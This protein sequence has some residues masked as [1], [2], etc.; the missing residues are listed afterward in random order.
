MCVILN[1]FW[2]PQ[3]SWR[4]LRLGAHPVRA[5]SSG[6]MLEAPKTAPKT[7]A[8]GNHGAEVGEGESTRGT[9]EDQARLLP[10]PLVTVRPQAPLGSRVRKQTCGVAP[11]RLCCLPTPFLPEAALFS[12]VEGMWALSKGLPA[13]P[14]EQWLLSWSFVRFLSS[15]L[16]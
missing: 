8:L 5:T 15:A 3:A 2:K 6:G 12:K 11:V 13:S 7:A 10:R 9:W 1:L 16:G 4:R 14:R